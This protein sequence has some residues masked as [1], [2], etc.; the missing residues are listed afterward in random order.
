MNQ[1]PTCKTEAR[2]SAKFCTFC[3]TPL[4]P[5]ESAAISAPNPMHDTTE[6][7]ESTIVVVPSVAEAVPGDQEDRVVATSWPS[8]PAAAW[9]T[10]TPASQPATSWPVHPNE[11]V[12]ANSRPA[13][14][15]WDPLGAPTDQEESAAGATPASDEVADR[16][17]MAGWREVPPDDDTAIPL[18]SSADPRS[19][20]SESA[21]LSDSASEGPAISLPAVDHE[22][23]SGDTENG[24]SNQPSTAES[25][26]VLGSTSEAPVDAIRPTIDETVASET[27]A[28]VRVAA[29]LDELRSL[30]T[31]LGASRL[32]P[33]DL[34]DRLQTALHD[35]GS[36]PAGLES[37]IDSA[38][39]KPRDLDAVLDLTAQL[40]GMTL[41]IDRHERLARS[42]Q[43][44]IQSLRY[45]EVE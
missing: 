34:A 42:M 43:E 33:G 14:Q 27:V 20:I 29:L 9:P 19:N 39:N 6:S 3:G 26:V 44:A 13:D 7:E 30:L 40:D 38:R 22:S 8:E 18:P 1:C 41:L 11:P 25:A 23:T 35:H 16:S 12:S 45:G 36:I 37:A 21:G 32:Q 5:D 10:A 4:T 17:E 24:E 2:P 28:R 15:T 31:S